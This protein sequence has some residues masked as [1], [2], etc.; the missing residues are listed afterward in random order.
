MNTPGQ[1]LGFTF[2]MGAVIF[3]CRAFPFL[4]FRGG[5]Q[6]AKA[7]AGAGKGNK[8]QAILNFVEKIV[9]PAAMTVLAFNSLAGNLGDNLRGSLPALI[10]AVVVALLH[11]WK[12][13]SLISIFGG[14]ALYM[15]LERIIIQN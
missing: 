15:V 1:A 7:D 4:F 2:A 14:T 12:R 11:L 13:N 6:G 3:F 5:E 10:A 8:A 9:P